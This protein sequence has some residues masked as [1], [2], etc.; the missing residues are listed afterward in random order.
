MSFLQLILIM[1]I[2]TSLTGFFCWILKRSI[3]KVEKDSQERENAR[4]KN[5]LYI[6]Q[7]LGAAFALSEAAA[8]AIQTGKHNGKLTSALSYSQKIKDIQINF[9]AE[10]GIENLY[11]K[12]R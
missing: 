7:G 11:S 10:L 4:I 2:P 12:E 6:I 3:D 1:G 5:E 9:L 8:E